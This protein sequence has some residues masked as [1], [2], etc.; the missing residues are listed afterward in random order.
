LRAQSE[1]SGFAVELTGQV[2]LQTAGA[3]TPAVALSIDRQKAVRVG[4]KV[5][6]VMPSRNGRQ[7]T[8]GFMPQAG[9]ETGPRLDAGKPFGVALD[10]TPGTVLGTVPT[11]VPE[12][13]FSACVG[14]PNGQYFDYLGEFRPAGMSQSLVRARSALFRA[15]KAVFLGVRN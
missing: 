13:S 7:I 15:R 5:R 11:V 3:V 14:G 8:V 10:T 9:L 2:G 4:R 1:A 6:P 12:V